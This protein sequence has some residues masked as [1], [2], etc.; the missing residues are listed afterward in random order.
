MTSA[1]PRTL[2]PRSPG[3]ALLPA[4][5]L[6]PAVAAS[7][8]VA[9][10]SMDSSSSTATN[11]THQGRYLQARAGKPFG[12]LAGS[13]KLEGGL[14]VDTATPLVRTGA[15]RKT[16]NG[17]LHA[18]GAQ[19]RVSNAL[20]GRETHTP[21]CTSALRRMRWANQRATGSARTML[22]AGSPRTGTSAT[23]AAPRARAAPTAACGRE[24]HR[25]QG[26]KAR[27]QD[28]NSD[29]AGAVHILFT[30]LPL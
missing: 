7:L 28:S 18:G 24:T 17:F 4:A 30:Q 9:T 25:V 1:G 12:V 5:A 3:S 20:Q 14:Q 27:E 10:G 26:L 13:L 11:T 22:W 23:W 8:A 2:S 6:P 21:V 15:L 29:G 16:R 19:Q